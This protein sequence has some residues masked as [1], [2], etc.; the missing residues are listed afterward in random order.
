MLACAPGVRWKQV[1][2]TYLM[3]GKIN[4]LTKKNFH[5][6]IL[7]HLYELLSRLILLLELMNALHQI[8]K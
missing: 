3:S 7:C 8:L 5:N 2:K 6:L 1:V 4:E